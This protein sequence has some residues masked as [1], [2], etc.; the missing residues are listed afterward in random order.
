MNTVRCKQHSE[1]QI[2]ITNGLFLVQSRVAC[3]KSRRRQGAFF[4]HG[5]VTLTTVSC[6]LFELQEQRSS[7]SEKPPSWHVTLERRLLA[8]RWGGTSQQPVAAWHR[9]TTLLYPDSPTIKTWHF[10]LETIWIIYHSLTVL[11]LFS[12]PAPLVPHFLSF[13]CCCS[14]YFLPLSRC[15]T[16]PSAAQNGHVLHSKQRQTKWR[17]EKELICMTGEEYKWTSCNIKKKK[18]SSESTVSKRGP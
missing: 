4:N 15:L 16:Q 3:H 13:C 14:L 6:R 7:P 17:R 11:L 8:C 5:C 12:L 2:N 9:V 10:P 18:T 1:A